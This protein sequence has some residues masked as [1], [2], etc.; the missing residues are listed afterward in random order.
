MCGKRKP[1]LK[2]GWFVVKRPDALKLSGGITWEDAQ[3]EEDKYF[4]T[5]LPWCTADLS[6][7]SNYGSQNLV[8]SLG[9]RL[10]EVI[11][12]R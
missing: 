11:K 3:S 1:I 7:R 6:Y 12:R 8:K 2:N 5:N 4:S 9:T 10:C